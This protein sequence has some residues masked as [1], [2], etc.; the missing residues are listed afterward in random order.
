MKMAYNVM[1]YDESGSSIKELLRT[2]D[3]GKAKAKLEELEEALE[4]RARRIGGVRVGSYGIEKEP[5]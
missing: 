5:V 2:V 1:A 3:K 4:K